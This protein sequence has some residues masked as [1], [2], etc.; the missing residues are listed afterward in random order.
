MKNFIFLSALAAA[1]LSAS[2]QH[3]QVALQANPFD[4]TKGLQTLQAAPANMKAS[5]AKRSI[6]DGV[7]Y[8]RPR[9][10]YHRVYSFEGGVPAYLV[11]GLAP[12]TYPN[13]CTNPG[14]AVWSVGD[15]DLSEY[16]DLD[17]NLVMTWGP[18]LY[19]DTE[20]YFLTG[21][22]APTISVG[23]S[24][25]TPDE[26]TAVANDVTPTMNFSPLVK[27]VYIG[28]NDGSAYGTNSVY[29]Q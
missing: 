29:E 24:S 2:A 16:A 26:V 11:P 15:T 21:Y 23:N 18:N 19:N 13:W 28:Y 22:V 9:G 10:C 8:G 25:F 20:Q 5:V 3:Q 4:L 12:V 7:L 17:N 6:E 27:K 14:A 1:S